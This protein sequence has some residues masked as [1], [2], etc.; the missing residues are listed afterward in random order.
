MKFFLRFS[1]SVLCIML[2]AAC[3]NKTLTGGVW[4]NENKKAEFYSDGTMVIT[5]QDAEKTYYYEDCTGKKNNK[6]IKIYDDK[7]KIT[8]G[9]FLRFIPYYIEGDVLRMDGAEY[10]F[11]KK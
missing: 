10:E 5:E 9:E 4:Q 2:L 6:Y 3:G 7:E 8:T 1:A 11:N